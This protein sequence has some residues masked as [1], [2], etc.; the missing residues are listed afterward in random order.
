MF[1]FFICMQIQSINILNFSPKSKTLPHKQVAFKGLISDVFQRSSDSK[2]KKVKVKNLKGEE[3]EATI[4]KTTPALARNANQ[5]T[6]YTISIGNYEKG[7][8]VIS[9]NFN[10]GVFLTRLHTERNPKREYKGL[11]TELIKHVV[12]ESIQK[13]KDGTITTCAHY[14]NEPPFKFYFKNNFKILD[15]DSL[16]VDY[17]RLYNAPLQYAVTYDKDIFDI[18]P[19]NNDT[20]YMKLD[21]KG[22]QALLEGK[23]LADSRICDIVATTEIDYELYSAQFIESPYEGEFFLQV[24]NEDM[25]EEKLCYIASLKPFE[26]E[27]GQKHFQINEVLNCFEASSDMVDDF[28]QSLIPELE[29]K[30]L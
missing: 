21:E 3:V 2:N 5:L 28:A 15:Y 18:I 26:D 16:D 8:A 1:N 23:R 7:K 12:Q 10:D 17:Q 11:G 4:T 19:K 20:F 14:E 30:Y 27:N 22:A 25:D 24:L 6:K 13:G 9:P 29:K